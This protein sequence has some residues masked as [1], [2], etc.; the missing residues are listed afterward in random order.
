ME[1]LFFTFDIPVYWF[2]PN[3]P[4]LCPLKIFSEFSS[5]NK[6]EHWEEL[7]QIIIVEFRL[8][9][10]WIYKVLIL[11]NKRTPISKWNTDSCIYGISSI[12]TLVK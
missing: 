12:A 7:G 3:I 6:K 8:F 4:F 11:K 9:P 1:I 2:L 5:G 10:L